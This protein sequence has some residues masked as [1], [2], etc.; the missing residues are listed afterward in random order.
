MG[1]LVVLL[2]TTNKVN[3]KQKPMAKEVK[4]IPTYIS[5]LES[6]KTKYCPAYKLCKH[7]EPKEVTHE[8]KRLI[9]NTP[10]E[11]INYLDIDIRTVQRF[12]LGKII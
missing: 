6:F 8:G 9:F 4:L 12:K 1:L 3:K 5:V 7:S 11:A 2:I 10:E